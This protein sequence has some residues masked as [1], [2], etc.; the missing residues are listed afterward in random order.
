MAPRVLAGSGVGRVGT[1]KRKNLE[2]RTVA[3][4]KAANSSHPVLS[5]ADPLAGAWYDFLL[6]VGRVLLGWIF[7][8]SGWSKLMTYSVFTGRMTGQGVPSFLAYLAPLIEFFGG[9]CLVLGLATRYAALLVILFTIAATWIAHRYWTMT[10]P[11]RGQN[12]TQFWKNVS[13]LGGLLTLFA[14]GPGSLSVDRLLRR[15]VR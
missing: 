12:H 9:L 11:A 13:I 7:L 3:D 5:Y 15:G 6:L 4:Q 1:A 2:G 8:Q 14:A 10:D